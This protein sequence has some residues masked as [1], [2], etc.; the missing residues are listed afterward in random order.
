MTA[1]GNLT[2][3]AKTLRIF[4]N[5][6]HL[7]LRDCK[8]LTQI[9]CLSKEEYNRFQ[10]IVEPR[11]RLA[12]A[13]AHVLVR[14]A[15]TWCAP[16]VP[17]SEW[18][19]Y[20]PSEGTRP[21]IS[22][23]ILENYLRFSLSHSKEFVAVIVT[24]SSFCGVDVE[25]TPSLPT[26]DKLARRICSK[27]EWSEYVSLEAGSRRSRFI[28]LWTLKEAASK[29][30]GFGLSIPFRDLSFTYCREFEIVNSHDPSWSI[31]QYLIPGQSCLSCAIDSPG[32]SFFFH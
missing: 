16:E 15:L 25:S 3:L 21:E 13:A 2:F 28:Q 8:E 1:Y 19:F 26:C 29:V 11:Q 5:E 30:L 31:L 22:G 24:L 7:W 27:A 32:I 23:P 18:K 20:R 4:E 10:H 14:K 6:A 17:E 9:D 12:Y